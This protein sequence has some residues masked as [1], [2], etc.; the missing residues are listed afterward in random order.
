[1]H[2]FKPIYNPEYRME[3]FKLVDFSQVKRLSSQEVLREC[4]MVTLSPDEIDV[5]MNVANWRVDYKEGVYGKGINRHAKFI[6]IVGESALSKLLHLPAQL[7]TK[8]EGD[9]GVDFSLS[10]R[11]SVD[12]KTASSRYH[13]NV[14]R[15]VEFYPPNARRVDYP[16][17]ADIFVGSYCMTKLTNFPPI[18]PRF[19]RVLLTGYLSCV[20]LNLRRPHKA[21]NDQAAVLNTE[22]YWCELLPMRKLLEM[23]H[24]VSKNSL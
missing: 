4:I 19:I 9:H 8:D 10:N 13:R 18:V 5:C 20:I 1:M 17:L 6:G 3:S 2:T 22:A 15:T 14:F 12:I 16:L 7:Q 11:K 23:H 21:W 24:G